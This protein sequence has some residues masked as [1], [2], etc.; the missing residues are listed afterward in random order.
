MSLTRPA[1]LAL[2]L[3]LAPLTSVAQDAAAPI[4]PAQGAAVPTPAAAEAPAD[5]EIIE[6]HG[7]SNFGVLK[8]GPDFEH[9]DYV[10]PD[11][12]KGGEFSTWASGTFDSMNPYSRKGRAGGLSSVFFE[13]MLTGVAD[14]IG[15]AYCL[16]CETLRYPEDK[17]WVEF[18]IRPEARFSDGTPMT[19]EDALFSYE[20]LRDQALPSVRA[21]IAS[22][23]VG[24]EVVDERTVRFTFTEDAPMR[25]RIESA[26][27]LP[28]FSKAWFE[29]TGARLDESRLDPA[30]GSGPYVLGSYDVN[31]RIV[32]ERDP[33][34]WGANL[35]IN[36]GRNNYDRIRL[37]YFGDGN[38]AFEA[39]KAGAYTFRLE[40]S[41]RIWATGYDFPAVQNGAVVV[42]ELPDGTIS[43]SQ[44][45]VMNLR[46]PQ[47]QDPRV[48]EAVGLMFNFEWTNA[49]LFYGL[50]ER[51][52]SFWEN[53]DLAARGA[54]TPEEAAVLEPLVEEGLL[55]ASILDEEAVVPPVSSAD[56]ALDRGN[57]RRASA[58]LDE[59]GWVV[60]DDGLRRKDG[61]TLRVEIIE[62]DPT[63]DRVINPYVENLRRVG[64]DAVYERV[65]PAQ[66]TDRERA[67][68]FDML[69]DQFPM[70]YEPG[71]ELFNYFHSGSTDDV[72]NSM[73]IA[74]PAVDRLIE[75]VRAADSQE[76]LT[77]AVRA[78]DRVLRAERFWVPQWFK[79]THTV[80]YY[81]MY[82]YPEVL[83]PYARGE[84]DFWWVDPEAEAAL[85]ASGA[86]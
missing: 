24:A 40:N 74:S 25:G 8:Y 80:A 3:S 55:P 83:P 16:L 60:G 52:T 54:P 37:E 75:V 58:L 64:I 15:S 34:Y 33:D 12:P 21:V 85:Q 51:M 81:D 36:V 57:L 69:V 47:F 9:L 63:F 29:G 53:T 42:E 19:A 61:R 26:G 79:D 41:S 2:A 65:D 32:Y 38:A 66:L 84:L 62:D 45:F 1:S 72:F 82:A 86:L 56:R 46:R 20:I 10:D 5:G 77:P 59:A 44:S 17:A 67:H 35:P 13:S 4:P 31:Q 68:D 23:I 39:F 22:Q 73:G 71:S 78:L 7:F 28:I 14:E 43:T 76:A 27:G 49:A 50:Y 11:A 48:R 6:S 30:L 70:S 18:T